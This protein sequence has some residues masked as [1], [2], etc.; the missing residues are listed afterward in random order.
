MPG[1]AKIRR[2]GGI[3]KSTSTTPKA[4]Q[5]SVSSKSNVIDVQDDSQGV[6]PK[7]DG[8]SSTSTKQELKGE[9]HPTNSRPPK[10]LLHKPKAKAKAVVKESEAEGA[11]NECENKQPAASRK[12]RANSDSLPKHDEPTTREDSQNT[13]AMKDPTFQSERSRNIPKS[14]WQKDN[15]TS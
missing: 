12:R 5:S 1:P 13:S 3:C 8:A 6:A 7:E 15:P 4:A 10:E 11:S 9:D 14:P 2:R